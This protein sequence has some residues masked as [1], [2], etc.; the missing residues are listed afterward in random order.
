MPPRTERS[1]SSHG[2]F[3]YAAVGCTTSRSCVS[4]KHLHPNLH[5]AEAPVA[6]AQP[7]SVLVNGPLRNR[8]SI[9]GRRGP[10]AH[11]VRK[12]L[13]KRP[14]GIDGEHRVL[15]AVPGATSLQPPVRGIFITDFAASFSDDFTP[16][17]TVL[18]IAVPYSS[19]PHR[20]RVASQCLPRF[21]ARRRTTCIPSE[22][23]ALNAAHATI[24]PNGTKAARKR[25]RNLKLVGG[26]G[27]STA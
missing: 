4:S 1:A 17:R 8:A 3:Y 9:A 23:A 22:R 26:P 6:T 7:C 14:A 10:V 11:R 12:S 21:A 16:G 15:R 13:L 25:P 2:L 5:F 20:P 24:K 27:S 19:I 18:G